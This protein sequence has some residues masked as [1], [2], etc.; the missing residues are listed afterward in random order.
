MSKLAISALAAT[1]A[2]FG[3]GAAALA[4]ECPADKVAAGSMTA[5]G[6]T[7]GKGVTDTV[8]AVNNLG[9]YYPELASRVQR[10]RY[11]TVEP[12]GEVPWHEH[13]DRPALIY[14]IEGTMTEYRSTCAVPIE[15]KAGE[16]AAELGPLQH[17]WRNNSA[18]PA[19]LISADMPRSAK[20]PEVM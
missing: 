5:A 20:A 13:G 15:H 1:V 10:I 6:H 12:G 7:E 18:E 9:D 2:V 19:R 3:L 17:W 14:M 4:G 16:V 11:L 8:L